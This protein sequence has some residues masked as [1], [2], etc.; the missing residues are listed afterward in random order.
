MAVISLGD[1][2][3][4]FA[5]AAG[6][7]RARPARPTWTGRRPP[8]GQRWLRREP[9]P[10]GGQ[11][12][13]S[14]TRP[15]VGHNPRPGR[16][17]ERSA[18]PHHVVVG[19]PGRSLDRPVVEAL[20]PERRVPLDGLAGQDRGVRAA[21][22]LVVAVLVAFLPAA[23]RGQV[24]NGRVN[25]CADPFLIVTVT[26]ADRRRT[27]RVCTPRAR[28][29][30]SRPRSRRRG[31]GRTPAHPIE[32]GLGAARPEPEPQVARRPWYSRPRRGDDLHVGAAVLN[33]RIGI[34]R[35]PR[36]SGGRHIRT[37]APIQKLVD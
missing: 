22:D 11:G 9:R 16:S 18:R 15:R 12:R 17:G 31:S 32:P 24:G 28:S 4:A 34:A 37:H 6:P 19:E 20:R 23:R 8:L 35:Q 21:G 29:R 5:R 27:C 3:L 7:E 14:S 25:R 30:S 1:G 36:R 26:L 2:E 33:A 13:G 10:C